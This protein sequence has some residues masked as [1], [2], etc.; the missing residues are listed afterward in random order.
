MPSFTS[1]REHH[2]EPPR[3]PT[4]AGARPSDEAG[5]GRELSAGRLPLRGMRRMIIVMI[6]ETIKIII[7]KM[8]IMIAI[9]IN[10]MI[11]LTMIMII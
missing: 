8:I 2:L 7:I 4:R 9:V 11:I 6:I 10:K 5:R 1:L 3:D